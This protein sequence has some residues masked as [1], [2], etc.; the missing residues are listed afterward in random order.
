MDSQE[1]LD[2]NRDKLIRCE[3]V[4]TT[5]TRAACLA[6]Q[7]LAVAEPR[8]HKE[9]FVCEQY[10]GPQRG[11]DA[12]KPG[13][14]DICGVP[15]GDTSLRCSKHRIKRGVNLRTGRKKRR[16]KMRIP[17]RESGK[18]RILTNDQKVS[19][20]KEYDDAE[21]GFKKDI[22]RQYQVASGLISKWR[23]E[24]GIS[25]G[26]DARTVESRHASGY[27]D[28]FCDQAAQVL[29]Q[30]KAVSHP[31]IVGVPDLTVDQLL[32]IATSLGLRSI[33]GQMGAE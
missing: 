16:A 7:G 13:H 30:M 9:C 25:K 29:G 27:K 11:E 5:M 21:P 24:L 22:L 19:I 10:K 20:V 1:W 18:R 33:A 28:H 14:C 26:V 17:K 2:Q 6:R 8:E 4:K 23:K 12:V 32:D 15:I 3:T 31:V